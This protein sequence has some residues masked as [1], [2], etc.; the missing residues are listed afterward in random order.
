MS[1][2]MVWYFGARTGRIDAITQGGAKHLSYGSQ[3]IQNIPVLHLYT[4]S[5]DQLRDI[6]YFQLF[7]LCPD[8]G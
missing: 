2:K 4:T 5:V 1:V 8:D 7:K 3:L 6:Q